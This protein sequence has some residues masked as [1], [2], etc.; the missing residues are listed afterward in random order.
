MISTAVVRSMT[1]LTYASYLDYDE[2]EDGFVAARRIYTTASQVRTTVPD[3]IWQIGEY[4]EG[5]L[6]WE[7]QSPPEIA[8]RR[9]AEPTVGCMLYRLLVYHNRGV[10]FFF[11]GSSNLQVN[12]EVVAD[13]GL[14]EQTNFVACHWKPNWSFPNVGPLVGNPERC[15][16]AEDPDM[17]MGLCDHKEWR[18][19][20][21]AMED[22]YVQRME[23]SESDDDD[24]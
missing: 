14:W 21:H 5:Q 13:E 19:L 11:R 15:D 1:L 7:Y 24:W 6:P 16:C 18:S 22:D 8:W 9:Y 20:V 17:D 2:H 23:L 4:W 12:G 10:N 3:I